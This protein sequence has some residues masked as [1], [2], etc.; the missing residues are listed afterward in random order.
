MDNCFEFLD[1]IYPQLSR[2]CSIFVGPLV[3]KHLIETKEF[4]LLFR[5][6]SLHEEPK[7]FCSNSEF[8]VKDK[9]VFNRE[10]LTNFCKVNNKDS[11]PETEFLQF[12]NVFPLKEPNFVHL[13]FQAL[14]HLGLFSQAKE[15]TKQVQSDYQDF[16]YQ[17][18]KSYFEQRHTSIIGFYLEEFGFSRLRECD[19]RNEGLLMHAIQHD[20]LKIVKVLINHCD[21]NKRVEGVVPAELAQSK[22]NKHIW[23]LIK[24]R[25][26]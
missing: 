6:I 20:Q 7:F 8:G 13:K 25:P 26:K 4:G 12:I 23:A 2:Q 11:I 19:P 1:E 3:T 9:I 24:N 10:D 22:G 15:L 14:A 17:R 16:N 5:V 18:L 21:P